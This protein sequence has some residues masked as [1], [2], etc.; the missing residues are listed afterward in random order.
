ME[1]VRATRSELLARRSQVM[2]ASRG[3]DVLRAKR[4]Q[5]MGEFRKTGDVILTSSEALDG[6][7]A[8][9]RRVLARAE[10]LDGPEAVRSAAV[11]SQRRLTITTSESA[12][13]GVHLVEILA[14]ASGRPRTGRGYSMAGSTPR[15]DDV[16]DR[17]EGIVDLFLEFAR[18]ELRLR[19]LVEEIR[20]T[21]R[22]VN[23]L[24]TVVIPRLQRESA[25]IRAVL[26]ERERQDRF[27]LKRS[28][29][30]RRARQN[31]GTRG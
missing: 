4:E 3:R 19:H 10:A 2:V 5:L 15:I 29:K 9:G 30:S 8:G 14:E 31:A 13:M 22:R 6:A 20:T 18:H 25:I 12:V 16:A 24:E 7:I 28:S 23:A 21:T 1:P 27:R 11:A 17:F 26:D